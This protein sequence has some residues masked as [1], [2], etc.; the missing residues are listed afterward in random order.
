MLN[1]I[2]S[3]VQHHLSY[4][5]QEISSKLAAYEKLERSDIVSQE[6]QI[7]Q[8]AAFCITTLVALPTIA[9]ATF[10]I[11]VLSFSL[12]ATAVLINFIFIKKLKNRWRELNR[13][14][15]FIQQAENIKEIGSAW[16][17]AIVK[18]DIDIEK[19]P[20]SVLS[21]LT[22][23]FKNSSIAIKVEKWLEHPFFHFSP[24]LQHYMKENLLAMRSAIYLSCAHK[25]LKEGSLEHFRAHLKEAK[26]ALNLISP[27]TRRYDELRECIAEVQVAASSSEPS[28]AL[29]IQRRKEELK[30]KSL[31]RSTEI[32]PPFSIEQ[33]LPYKEKI[34]AVMNEYKRTSYL[35]IPKLIKRLKKGGI[36]ISQKLDNQTLISIPEL[37]NVIFCTMSHPSISNWHR[38]ERLCKRKGLNKITIPKMI[39]LES[40][41]KGLIAIEKLDCDSSAINQSLYFDFFTSDPDLKEVFKEYLDQ[42]LTLQLKTGLFISPQNLSLL[43]NGRGLTL[44]FHPNIHFEQTYATTLSLC[45][46]FP[47]EF[48][49]QIKAKTI[50]KF[51]QCAS[52]IEE[53][54]TQRM[55]KV[56]QLSAQRK[57]FNL[58]HGI[59]TGKEP[60][61]INYAS[62]A[63]TDEDKVTFQAFEKDV[64][65][66]LKK[67]IQAN[68]PFDQTRMLL[69]CVNSAEQSPELK[70]LHTTKAK[71]DEITAKLL[72]SDQICDI[73][74]SGT[75]F[76]KFYC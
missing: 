65:H 58:R 33:V 60:F 29:K 35:R 3:S 57:E 56:Y 26:V 24:S 31:T 71:L 62:L 50:A 16:L 76:V 37:P 47:L 70:A 34:L 2:P 52:E 68:L 39:R 30:A 23:L 61:R 22:P 41:T 74:I 49:P 54:F 1:P 25:S 38:L 15:A 55:L 69:I 4:V 45:E 72:A 53:K 11:T 8:I 42:L 17:Q 27:D 46:A 18:Y 48:L 12:T 64:N 67:N 51:P 59:L 5:K 20:Q 21:L 28:E 63:L 43:N 36:D 73:F 14:L 19:K 9:L 44:N 40:W 66:D 7:S 10:E 13:Q 6:E 75:D 32:S